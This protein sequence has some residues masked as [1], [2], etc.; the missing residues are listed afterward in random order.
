M[1]YVPFNVKKKR[2]KERPVKPVLPVKVS[3]TFGVH[4]QAVR[5]GA[6]VRGH[7]M[8]ADGDVE[9]VTASDVVAQRLPVHRDQTRPGLCNPEPLRSPHRFFREIE[10]NTGKERHE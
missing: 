9:G 5:F 7:V 10:E 6:V 8:V 4:D 2:N 3:L 1:Q